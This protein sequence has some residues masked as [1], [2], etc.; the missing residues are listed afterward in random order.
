MGERPVFI[1]N[2]TGAST[3]AFQFEYIPIRSAPGAIVRRARSLAGWSKADR[4][5]E[6]DKR[7]VRCQASGDALRSS[8]NPLRV[9]PLLIA[10]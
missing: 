6:V 3:V 4:Q 9:G 5:A 8:V 2:T 10:N 1:E 7:T